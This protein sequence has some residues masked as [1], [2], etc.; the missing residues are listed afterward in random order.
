MTFVVGTIL[1]IKISWFNMN[2]IVHLC[3]TTAVA[4]T[5]TFQ[6]RLLLKVLVIGLCLSALAVYFAHG[7]LSRIR[8]LNT[9]QAY[10]LLKN[11]LK[12]IFDY[13]GLSP[14]QWLQS[15][16]NTEVLNYIGLV[17]FS[18]FNSYS[19]IP[20]LTF[21]VLPLTIGHCITSALI[22]PLKNI[23][24]QQSVTEVINYLNFW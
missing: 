4:Q 20:T 17:M 10:L 2:K 1:L 21:F 6:K 9:Y 15:L 3:N 24:E 12:P 23:D 13:L 19:Y 5:N 7:I 11:K 14:L 8:V 16:F 18:F 22:E